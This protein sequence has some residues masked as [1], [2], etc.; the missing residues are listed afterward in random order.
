MSISS[1]NMNLHLKDK[2]LVSA[3]YMG[4]NTCFHRTVIYMMSHDNSG[5][6]GVVVNRVIES[7]N[8]NFLFDALKIKHENKVTFPVY[9]GGPVDSEKGLV[10]HSGEYD[11]KSLI[12]L[13]SGLS[14]SSNTDILTDIAHGGGPKEK[15]LVLGYA[16][17]Q[18]GQIE[19]EIKNNSWLI[20]PFTNNLIFD[21]DNS[22][23]WKNALASIGVTP[24]NYCSSYGN[25]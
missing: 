19:D 15:M 10:L 20:V 6:F 12:N 21:K 14:L 22:I 4:A 3:P 5:A 13:D 7:L 9:F 17:W 23:K 1:L 8:A 24:G 16:G 2:L 18:P 25:A 11:C